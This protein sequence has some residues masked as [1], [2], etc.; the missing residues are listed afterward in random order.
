[1]APQCEPTFYLLKRRLPASESAHLLGRVV[2]EYQDPTFDYTP[3]EPSKSLTPETF[4]EFL[5]GVQHEK[6]A[7]I[8]S[9]ASQD[10]KLWARL[11]G[12]LLMSSSSAAGGSTE[13]TSPEITTRRIKRETDYFKALKMVP[14]VRRKVL[15]MCPLGGKVYLI[16]GTMSIQTAEF[17]LTGNRH[18]NATI[19]GT[20]PVGGVASAA[21]ASGG[22]PLL[23]G[24]ANAQVGGQQTN[25]VDSTMEFSVDSTDPDEE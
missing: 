18:N 8:T 15:E 19:A 5:L 2:Q 24:T 4:N 6:S 22:V 17:K 13:V 21:A 23:T 7:H 20:L 12:L 11:K 25:S 1:M 9:R 10:A 3:E 14:E 16:V